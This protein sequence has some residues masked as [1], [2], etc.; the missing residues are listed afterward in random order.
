MS[1]PIDQKKNKSNN[2]WSTFLNSTKHNVWKVLLLAYV[3]ANYLVQA[4]STPE[5]FKSPYRP[6]STASPTRARLTKAST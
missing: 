4:K 3:G 6:T 1:T 2:D 5:E